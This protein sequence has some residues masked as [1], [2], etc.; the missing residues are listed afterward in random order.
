MG[1]GSSSAARENVGVAVVPEA[2]PKLQ[3]PEQQQQEVSSS[4]QPGAK[5]QPAAA[6]EEGGTAT[7]SPATAPIAPASAPTSSA[8]ASASAPLGVPNRR[9]GPPIPVSVLTDSYKA[10]HYLMVS[11][12]PGYTSGWRF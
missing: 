12:S 10:S 9:F 11:S 5:Q 4:Q 1:C 6:S 2:A 7:G 3:Q 8:S